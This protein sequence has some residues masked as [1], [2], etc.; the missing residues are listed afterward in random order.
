M[1]VCEFK[2]RSDKDE[3]EGGIKADDS[4]ENVLSTFESRFAHLVFAK[5][6][7]MKSTL[8]ASDSAYF[9]LTKSIAKVGRQLTLACWV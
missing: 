1:S 4:S 5:K 7:S 9:E 6:V 2:S 8:A 3:D